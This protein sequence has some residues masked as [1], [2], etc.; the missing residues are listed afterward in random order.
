MIGVCEHPPPIARESFCT[1]RSKLTIDISLRMVII[2]NVMNN[3][4][5]KNFDLLTL[6]L[7]G[8]RL[9]RS[10]CDAVRETR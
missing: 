1:A 4:T 5:L 2:K 9:G 7:G 8:L 6:R 3:Y 10:Y